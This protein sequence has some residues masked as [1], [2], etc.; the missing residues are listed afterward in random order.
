MKID[1]PLDVI[2]NTLLQFNEKQ[3]AISLVATFEKYAAT[4]QQF[5]EIARLYNSLK[6]YTQSVESLKKAISLVQTEDQLYSIRSNLAKLYNAKNDPQSALSVLQLNELITPNDTDILLEKALCHYFLGEYQ[7]SEDIMRQILQLNVSEQIKDRALYN[8]ST[9]KLEH[10]NFKEGTKDHCNIGRKI[11]VHVT[12]QIPNI[13]LWDGSIIEGQ[14]VV[15]LSEGGLGDE[16]IALR[17]VKILQEKNMKPIFVTRQKQLIPVLERH[18]YDYRLTGNNNTFQKKNI[19]QCQ[20]FQLPVLLDL[21]K[22]EVWQGSYLTPSPEYLDK[23]KKLL[24]EGKKIA[25]K[26]FGNN[27]YDQDLHR[28][29]SLDAL[30]QLDV[31]GATIISIQLEEPPILPFSIFD[32]SPYIKNVEDT[33]AIL[34][35]C[36][37]TVSSCTS[38][39]HMAGAMNVPCIVCPPIAAYYPWLGR[40]DGKSNWYGENMRV[41]R[42]TVHKNWNMV[43]EKVNKLLR[44]H[45]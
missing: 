2:V 23:W 12:E 9:Y 13:P 20:A 34:Y 35:L 18:N 21:D 43:I 5:D 44:E 25:L 4:L 3:Q 7:K 30:M 40:S 11:G 17:F 42:Q 31:G 15:I 1:N 8:L 29:I 33:L 45:R 28:G 22:D 38:V 6:C 24:P 39:V 14:T 41:V 36:T 16:L 37:C 32:A 10:G 19:V 26:T 27:E